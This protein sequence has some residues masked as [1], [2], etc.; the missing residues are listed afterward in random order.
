MLD[1]LVAEDSTLTNLVNALRMKRKDA[2][3]HL[4]AMEAQGLVTQNPNK[5][6]TYSIT[7]EGV[8]WLKR[9]KGLTKKRR[10]KDDDTR[11]DFQ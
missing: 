5:F 9:Y 3:E 6:V 2:R 4:Q 10:S 8:R 11:T 7:E 1:L